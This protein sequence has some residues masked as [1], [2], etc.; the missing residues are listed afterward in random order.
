MKQTVTILCTLVVALLLVSG[1]IV[2]SNVHMS[3]LLL[4]KDVLINQLCQ[5]SAQQA[6]EVSGRD[7]AILTLETALSQAEEALG[8]SATALEQLKQSYSRLSQEAQALAAALASDGIET[9]SPVHSTPAPSYQPI[10]FPT[11]LP[12]RF[13]PQR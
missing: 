1:Y 5:D 6:A 10:A 8:A 3:Q 4:E 13:L 7:A 2:L 11:P 12:V 9:A